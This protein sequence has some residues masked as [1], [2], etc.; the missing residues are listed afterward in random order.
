LTGSLPTKTIGIVDVARDREARQEID[1]KIQERA[2]QVVPYIPI[3]QW[4]QKT[5]YR[6]NIKGY[7]SAPAI[8][9]WNIEKT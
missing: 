6:K 1:A 2:F 4:T 7:I 5:A 8:F 9:M 3:G